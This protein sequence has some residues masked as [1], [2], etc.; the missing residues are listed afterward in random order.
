MVNSRIPFL[1]IQKK[2][3]NL[4]FGQRGPRKAYFE[5]SNAIECA[6]FGAPKGPETNFERSEAVECT[7]FGAPKGP[8]RKV[9]LVHLDSAHKLL[10]IEPIAI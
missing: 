3:K 8:E 4:F 6:L 1:S 2:R 10:L 5:E 9:R 7:L